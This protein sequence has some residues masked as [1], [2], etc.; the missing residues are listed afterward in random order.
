MLA[1]MFERHGDKPQRLGI[2]APAHL[3]RNL[4]VGFLPLRQNGSFIREVVA[5]QF[6][7]VVVRLSA[8]LRFQKATWRNTSPQ[9]RVPLTSSG[10]NLSS[11]IVLARSTLFLDTTFQRATSTAVRTS[12]FV[13]VIAM[14][15]LTPWKSNTRSQPIACLLHT[16]FE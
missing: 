4:T 1:Q 12:S 13:L 15:S 6:I 2:E 5:R 3:V 14:K 7:G 10:S 8:L 16:I 11:G 9:L